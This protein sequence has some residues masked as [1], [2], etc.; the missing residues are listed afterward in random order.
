MVKFLLGQQGG[1][2]KY[3]CFLCLWDN[4]AKERHWTQ[5]TWQE[6]KKFQISGEKIIHE[7]LVPRDKIIL[8]PL[9]IKLELMKQYVEALD[10]RTLFQIFM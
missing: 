7:P 1:Y 4:R 9:H 10:R 6:R 2:T 5:K 3:P 8:P